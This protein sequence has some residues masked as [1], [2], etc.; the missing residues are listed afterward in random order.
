MSSCVCLPASLCFSI[1]LLNVE[2]I[3]NCYGKSNVNETNGKSNMVPKQV[4]FRTV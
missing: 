1:C 3:L 2:R 4:S